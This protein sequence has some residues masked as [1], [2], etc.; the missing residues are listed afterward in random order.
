MGLRLI[1]FYLTLPINLGII[2]KRPVWGIMILAA[3]YFIRPG[4]WGAPGFLRPIF[5]FTVATAISMLINKSDKEW[6]FP[7]NFKFLVML[8]VVMLFSTIF[9][10]V[11]KQAAMD[12]NIFMLKLFLLF[13]MVVNIVD[14]YPKLNAV[15]W[16][17]VFGCAWATKAVIVHYLIEGYAQVDPLVGQGGGSNSFGTALV[18][19]L[20]FLFFK[21]FSS[22]KWER[23]IAIC[24]IPLWLIS[25]VAVASRGASL[26]LLIVSALLFLRSKK[27]LVLVVCLAAASVV[28]FH[29]AGDYFWERMDTIGQYKQDGSAQIRM[30]QWRAGMQ[31]FSEY[32]IT[33]VGPGNF[34]YLSPLY[35]GL[36]VREG[37]GG[38]FVAHNTYIE[39]LAETGFAG[40]L[41][42]LLSIIVTIVGLMKMKKTFVLSKSLFDK[43]KDF[44]VISDALLLGIIA[45]SLH[46]V[47]RTTLKSDID[48]WYLALAACFLYIGADLI[49]AQKKEDTV[50][51]KKRFTKRKKVSTV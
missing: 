51:K 29:Y 1:F 49:A 20:P 2:F 45:F 3:G 48:Y 18:M 39:L 42:Y 46:S 38:G 8:F 37:P 15:C 21:I 17:L 13:F 33:G 35:T 7:L 22:K 27:K 4:L 30:A 28:F 10:V 9:S 31:M 34:P 14:S 23:I 16:A 12:T 32:P 24:F 50:K 47:T 5:I 41:F 43:Y 44:I 36:Q 40:L 11:T 6:R 25:L 19:T 26:V